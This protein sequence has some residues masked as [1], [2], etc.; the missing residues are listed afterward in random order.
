MVILGGVSAV[1]Y[2]NWEKNTHESGSKVA[3]YLAGSDRKIEELKPNFTCLFMGKNQHLTDFIMLAQ[4]NPNTRQ[5]S[6][7]SIPR[8]TYV[9]TASV[10]GKIN[11]IYMNKYPEKV[12]SKVQEITGVEIQHYV[13]FDTK[14]L[15]NIVNEIGG[16]TVDVPINMDYDDPYQNL[17]IHLKKGVQKLTGAQA[18]Q[19]VRYRKGN[20]G[21]GGYPNG[22]IGRIAAQHN[23]IKALVS[24]VLKP[25]NIGKINNLVKIVLDGTKT[26]ITLDTI[27][28]YLG[29]VVTFKSDRMRSETLPG[30]DKYMAPPYGGLPLS[31][32]IYN[33]EETKVLVDDLFYGKGSASGDSNDSGESLESG[34]KSSVSAPQEV[35]SSNVVVNQNEEIRL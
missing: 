20:N 11:S 3:Q 27:E 12:V 13:V 30:I 33:P 19:F 22:D 35:V 2:E 7:L 15:R 34:D 21:K 9:G 1:Y 5:V 31:Y 16:V 6:L 4:Y 23:F 8:D 25:E 26:D 32:W 14:I 24:E 18:E 17:Y 29:D 10:D 28:E